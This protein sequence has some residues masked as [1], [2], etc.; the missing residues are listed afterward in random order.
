[1]A[2]FA[3]ATEPVLQGG[4]EFGFEFGVLGTQLLEFSEQFTNHR[5]ERGHIGRHRS[6]GTS[7]PGRITRFAILLHL[8]FVTGGAAAGPG[9][10]T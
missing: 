9:E 7:L 6:T 1:M 4:V 8:S 3:P 5:L 2:T 10:T